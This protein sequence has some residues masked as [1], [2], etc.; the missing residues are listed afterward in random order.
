[1]LRK[2]PARLLQSFAALAI[3]AVIVV[4]C[5]KVV[6]VNQTTIA[7]TLLVAILAVSSFWGFAV[8]KWNMLKVWE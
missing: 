4:F 1:M 5:R 6:P 8:S 3:V 2:F 7:L